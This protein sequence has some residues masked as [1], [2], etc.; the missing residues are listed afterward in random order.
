MSTNEDSIKLFQ[1]EEEIENVIISKIN[2]ITNTLL[3]NNDSE[4][5]FYFIKNEISLAP[6]GM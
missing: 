5:Y 4:L 2:Y 6:F 1:Q 3:R